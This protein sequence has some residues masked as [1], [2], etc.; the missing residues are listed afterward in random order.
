MLPQGLGSNSSFSTPPSPPRNGF[1][2]LLTLSLA[3]TLFL[4][5]PSSVLFLSSSFL[6]SNLPF[7]S[8][9]IWYLLYARALLGS[10]DTEDRWALPWWTS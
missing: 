8:S 2:L 1:S 3:K 5:K 10:R 7:I 9:N 6:P 4:A